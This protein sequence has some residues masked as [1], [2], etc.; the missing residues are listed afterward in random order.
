M[1]KYIKRPIE[2]EAFQSGVDD[3]P[4]WAIGK[5]YVR[6]DSTTGKNLFS[7]QTS[8]G[9][10]CFVVG[11]YIIKGIKG[12]IYPCKKDIFEET[13][14][15]KDHKETAIN[16]TLAKEIKRILNIIN[17]IREKYP[18]I[19]PYG[20]ANI[21]NKEQVLTVDVCNNC[22]NLIIDGYLIDNNTYCSRDCLEGH[23]SSE[24]I[25]KIIE[26]NYWNSMKIEE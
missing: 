14:I 2:V 18:D 15:T 11:D 9:E 1:K 13:Y 22:G 17:S 5:I 16:V 12:E 20:I 21:I 6:H 26:N 8:E 24:R 4:N 10:M 7:I 25:D 3:I 23:Y 19:N